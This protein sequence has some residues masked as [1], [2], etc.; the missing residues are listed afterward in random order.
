MHERR[1]KC[2]PCTHER[3]GARKRKVIRDPQN[4]VFIDH[5]LV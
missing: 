2:D 5:N 3:S 4:V 1:I